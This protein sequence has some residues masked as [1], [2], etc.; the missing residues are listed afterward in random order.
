MRMAVET[1]LSRTAVKRVGHEG[2]KV[3]DGTGGRGGGGGGLPHQVS[4]LYAGEVYLTHVAAVG[5][6]SKK[7]LWDWCGDTNKDAA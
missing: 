6:C 2:G 3:G 7:C 1:D 4:E 5:N